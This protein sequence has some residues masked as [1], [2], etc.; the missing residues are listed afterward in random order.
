MRRFLIPF[1]VSFLCVTALPAFAQ[2]GT[3]EIGG[4]VTD[5]QGGVL[6]GV[7]IV[8]TRGRMSSS[9]CT[10]STARGAVVVPVTIR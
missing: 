10:S 3:A 7:A 8:I 2:Q 4:K 6:P 9:P 1:V 5:D